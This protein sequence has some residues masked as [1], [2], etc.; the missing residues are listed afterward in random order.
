VNILSNEQLTT[1][2]GGDGVLPTRPPQLQRAPLDAT[3]VY[4]RDW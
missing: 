4:E 3:G 2:T 1:V